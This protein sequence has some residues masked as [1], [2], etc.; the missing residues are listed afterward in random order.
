MT[1]TTEQREQNIKR[2][3][4]VRHNTT[5]QEFVVERTE[6]WLDG[7]WLHTIGGAWVP[8]KLVTKV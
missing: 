3:D 8:V 7:M 4:R 6:H 5:G 2:G 1:N